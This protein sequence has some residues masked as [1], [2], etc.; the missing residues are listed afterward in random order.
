METNNG[1]NVFT[2]AGDY[3]KAEGCY[4]DYYPSLKRFF[5][6]NIQSTR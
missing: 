3:L 2:Q 6:V 1:Q 5:Q 4:W